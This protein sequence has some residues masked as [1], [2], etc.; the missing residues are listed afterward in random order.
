MHV[1]VGY[2]KR[3]VKCN[4]VIP[5]GDKK[6]KTKKPIKLKAKLTKKTGP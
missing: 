4:I 2:K 5:R 3:N 1:D 6:K